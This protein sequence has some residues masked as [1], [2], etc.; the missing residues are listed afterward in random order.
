[1]ASLL[2]EVDFSMTMEC[3]GPSSLGVASLPEEFGNLG[4]VRHRTRNDESLT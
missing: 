4:N 1:M 3:M 2:W